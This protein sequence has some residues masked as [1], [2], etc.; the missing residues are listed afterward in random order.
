MIGAGLS[1]T[2][3]GFLLS[4]MSL[5]VTSSLNAR[6]AMVLLGVIVSLLGIVAMIAPGYAKRA[7]WRKM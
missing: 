7:I 4:V 2:F 5:G 6:L 3:L 1:I